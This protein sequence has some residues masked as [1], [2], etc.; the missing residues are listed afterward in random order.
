MGIP[1]LLVFIGLQIASIYYFYKG[2]RRGTSAEKAVFAAAGAGLFAH[3]FFGIGDAITLWDRLAFWFWW[4]LALG[5]AQ[6]ALQREKIQ[7]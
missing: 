5:G 6:Y 3:A 2:Y 4:L 1:G 7:L